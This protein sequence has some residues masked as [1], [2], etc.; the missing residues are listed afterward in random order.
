MPYLGEVTVLRAQKEHIAMRCLCHW[1]YM[2]R[3]RG[4]AFSRC[5]PCQ[6]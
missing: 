1:G 3:R 4:V 2:N 5:D 6:P